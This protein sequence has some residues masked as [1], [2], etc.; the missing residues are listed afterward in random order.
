MPSTF[1]TDLELELQAS[2]ENSGTWGTIT[3]T[4]LELIEQ[5]ISGV[6]S[7]ALSNTD[8]TLS[9]DQQQESNA[10]NMVLSFTGTL[11]S[12]VNVNFPASREKFFTIIDSTTHANNTLTFKVTGNS[13]FLLAQGNKYICHSDG[14]NIVKDLEFKNWRAITSS[15]TVQAGSQLLVDTSSNTVTVTLPASPSV[16]DEVSIIDSKYTFDTNNLTVDRNGSN[17]LNGTSNL[18]VAVEGAGFTLVYV[19]ATVGWTYKEK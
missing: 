19:N 2:G 17:L 8:V 16:G 9:M 3:N 12:N 18:T 1:S 15:E 13:G 5:A 4:N 14:T 11:T 10:R 7:I 6:E